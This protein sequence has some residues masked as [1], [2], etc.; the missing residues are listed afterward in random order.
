LLFVPASKAIPLTQRMLHAFEEKSR[1]EVPTPGDQPV[2]LSAGVAIAHAK[3]PVV[4]FAGL[5]QDLLKSAKRCNKNG[6]YGAQRQQE[7][8]DSSTLDYLVVSEPSANPVSKIRE[9]ELTYQLEGITHR[10]T[11]RPFTLE[12]CRR[13]VDLVKELKQSQLS[14][15]RLYAL[16]ESLYQGRNHSVLQYLSLINR[17]Q[18]NQGEK[19]KSLLH[20]IEQDKS[21]FPDEQMFPWNVTE[22]ECC[23]PLLDMME[24]YDFVGEELQ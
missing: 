15:S 17:L 12:K 24:I 11:Q 3:Y 10:L 23:T 16:F 2:T 7:R 18:G 6:W 4:S 8:K 21:L 1:R 9:D 5:A 22:D 13:V 19:I 20:T 14:R